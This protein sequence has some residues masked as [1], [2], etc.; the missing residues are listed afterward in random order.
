[1]HDRMLYRLWKLAWVRDVMS[2]PPMPESYHVSYAHDRCMLLFDHD[3]AY[4]ELGLDHEAAKRKMD[5]DVI[6]PGWR[7]E[8][9]DVVLSSHDWSDVRREIDKRVPEVA[10]DAG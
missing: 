3:R 7:M 10:G 5:Q 6:G 4:F 9:L 2:D 8:K 1:M